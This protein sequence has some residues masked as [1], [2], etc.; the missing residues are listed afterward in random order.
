M[1]KRED[2]V[3]HMMQSKIEYL[4]GQ[5]PVQVNALR[6]FAPEVCDFLNDLS[7]SVMSYA[8]LREYPDLVTFAYWCRK[9]NIYKMKEVYM[10]L[11]TRLGRGTVFHIAPSN[12]PINFAFS[13]VF[14][15]LSGNANIVRA[16]SHDFEQTG[17]ICTLM[18]QLLCKAEYQFLKQYIMI[19]QYSHDKEITDYFSSLCDA[20]IIWGGDATIQEIRKSPIG[21]RTVEINFADRYS[22][23]VI[24]ADYLVGLSQTQMKQLAHDFYNDTYLI[25]QNACSTPHLIL[26]KGSLANVSQAQQLFWDSVYA[27]SKNYLLA[28]IKASEKYTMLCMELIDDNVIIDNVYHYDN[29]LYR[30]A[31][32][33]L[34]AQ[35]DELRG[36]YGL[37]YEYTLRD[38]S[39]LNE[40]ISTKIQTIVYC[41]LKAD[42]I[43]TWVMEQGLKGIDRIVPFGQALDI[44]LVWDGYDVIRTLSRVIAVK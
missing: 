36:K 25:D 41:G 26:W 27:E 12:V 42:E 6:P 32:N 15:L 44:S 14:G 18:N 19:V 35:I 37:F 34:P 24:D 7:K 39:E 40:L 17:I 20:R 8:H 33:Q 9:S 5:A 38:F 28:P 11:D 4:V 23:G 2:A 1:L 13:L 30:I 22:F 29:Y 43:R 16:S 3:I 21:M 31:L 10:D